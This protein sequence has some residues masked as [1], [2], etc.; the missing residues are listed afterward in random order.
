MRS[1][2]RSKAFVLA[3]TSVQ[4]IT[5]Q[6]IGE[7]RIYLKTD[8]TDCRALSRLGRGKYISKEKKCLQQIHEYRVYVQLKCIIPVWLSSSKSLYFKDRN[9]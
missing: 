6:K 1:G 7:N 8:C 4:L 5:E 3:T 9:G 2:Q